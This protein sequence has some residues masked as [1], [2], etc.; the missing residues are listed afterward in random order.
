MKPLLFHYADMSVIDSD[1]RYQ[2][3]NEDNNKLRNE[4]ELSRKKPSGAVAYV[5][6]AVGFILISLSFV[7]SSQIA[8][9]IGI[10]VT[11]WGGLLTFL[12][13]AR[14]VRND[15]LNSV[16]LGATNAI[17][18]IREEEGYTGRPWFFSPST[19]RGIKRVVQF[20]PKVKSVQPISSNVFLE[21]GIF[22]KDPPGLRFR[23][24]GIDLMSLLENTLGTNFALVDFEYLEANLGRAIVDYLELARLF[25]INVDDNRVDVRISDIIFDDFFADGR[26]GT[27]NLFKID[28]LT[29]A[30]ACI[31]A[32]VSRK[33]IVVETYLWESEKSD[34]LVSFLLDDL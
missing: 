12:R 14:Y 31:L 28:P 13:P 34:L 22:S 7:H 15:V 25:E 21:E 8:A 16:A 18:G 6:L 4:L 26:N 3:L 29:S 5:L 10:A 11:F 23:P 33:L 32:I 20:I 9:I 19:I 30:L 2:R 24:S 27:P 17:L 1:E